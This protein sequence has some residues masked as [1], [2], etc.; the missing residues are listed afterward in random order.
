MFC[1]SC[2]KEIADGV[3]FCP[4][5]GAVVDNQTGETAGMPEQQKVQEKGIFVEGDMDTLR[6]IAES[7]N[8]GVKR[9]RNIGIALAVIYLV[10]TAKAII[11]RIGEALSGDGGF[12]YILPGLAAMILL[13]CG[14]T[15]LY[16]EIVIPFVQGKKAG[17]AEE[18]L[19]LIH[20]ESGWELQ[21]ALEQMKCSAIKKVYMDENGTVCVRG[22]KCRHTF[23]NN[24]GELVMISQKSN[25][26]AALERETIAGWLLKSLA[27]EAPVNAYE[28]ERNNARL[29]RLNKIL[30]VVALICGVIVVVGAVNPDFGLGQQKYIRMVKES[31]PQL[32]PDITYGQAFEAFFENGRWIYFQSEDKQDIVEFS[33]NCTY[34]GEKAEI[35]IQ[36]QVWYDEGT[37]QLYTMGINDE[38]QSELVQAFLLAEI[39]ESYNAGDNSQNL[40]KEDFEDN[41]YTDTNEYDNQNSQK[42]ETIADTAGQNEVDKEEVI[43]D[44]SDYT[45]GMTF[46]ILV[47]GYEDMD[48]RCP[49]M[50]Q[51]ET[52]EELV[53]G[54]CEEMLA[55]CVDDGIT[56]YVSPVLHEDTIYTATKWD[57]YVD[58]WYDGLQTYEQFLATVGWMCKLHTKY[59]VDSLYTST[60]W[61]SISV[62]S[63]RWG[64]GNADIS[65]SIFSDAS[66]YDAM[67]EIG[68]F[69]LDKTG[70]TGSLT[71]LGEN[72]NEV[73][74]LCKTDTGEEMEIKYTIDGGINV[75]SAS[76]VYEAKEGANL[77]CFERYVS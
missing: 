6:Q 16:L 58:G 48:D 51:E 3:R 45:A 67:E 2:G 47:R 11:D 7:E 4:E 8:K 55:S 41:S 62:L 73:Y 74:I 75:L 23:G 22:R 43:T 56:M 29:S 64:D 53:R 70:L 42:E 52:D 57:A 17:L 28:K 15:Y 38:P 36:F 27:P 1:S 34:D 61:E 24:Q 69:S 19:K 40:V 71:F 49:V 65:I 12:G 68:T 50:V 59:G 13:G 32:Y 25:Y 46:P 10:L 5:C 9:C 77:M 44:T 60:S 20:V 33:G 63:G 31:T 66:E 72:D 21:Q 30:A 76:E 26:K 18:Y 35:R 14:L 39:F 37:Y 54:T